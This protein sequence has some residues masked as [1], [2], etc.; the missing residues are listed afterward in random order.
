M[1]FSALS[2]AGGDAPKAEI[3]NAQS[4]SPDAASRSASKRQGSC[5]GVPEPNPVRMGKPVIQPQAAS[6]P[7]PLSGAARGSVENRVLSFKSRT[8]PLSISSSSAPRRPAVQT[9]TPNRASFKG[10]VSEFERGQGDAGPRDGTAFGTRAQGAEIGGERRAEARRDDLDIAVKARD[11]RV[12]VRRQPHDPPRDGRSVG[13]GRRPQQTLIQGWPSLPQGVADEKQDIGAHARFGGSG[14][15][16]AGFSQTVEVA[17][18]GLRMHVLD[19]PAEA[20]GERDRRPHSLNI[21]AQS[22]DERL[23]ASLQ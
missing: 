5:S 10:S 17:Q 7:T 19:D 6:A 22:R 21:G 1:T 9:A 12:G 8:R 4:V 15:H 16:D 11:S 14:E 20:F 3:H 23:T 2:H 18:Q 13:S